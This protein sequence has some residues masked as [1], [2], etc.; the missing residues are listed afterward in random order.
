ME[1]VLTHEVPNHPQLRKHER[2][3]VLA[4]STDPGSGVYYVM[5]EEQCLSGSEAQVV[6]VPAGFCDIRDGSLRSGWLLDHHWNQAE[7]RTVIRLGP[8]A[9]VADWDRRM[10]LLALGDESTI[11]EAWRHAERLPVLLDD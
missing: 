4:F 10:E 3:T 9:W 8:Q 2:R 11:A 7:N 1:I 6:A 5:E